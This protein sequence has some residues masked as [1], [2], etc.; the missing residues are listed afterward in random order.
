[1][2]K[3]VEILVGSCG[4]PTFGTTQKHFELE[5]VFQSLYEWLNE[6]KEK[7]QQINQECIYKMEEFI[8]KPT[9]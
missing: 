1:M 4:L 5:G 6:M 8:S 3:D 2:W 9:R 7:I